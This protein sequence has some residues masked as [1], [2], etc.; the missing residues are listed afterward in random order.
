MQNQRENKTEI[1]QTKEKIADMRV[2][3]DRSKE[4]IFFVSGFFSKAYILMKNLGFHYTTVR[5]SVTC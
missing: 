2:E 4:T 3:V 1:T 5:F